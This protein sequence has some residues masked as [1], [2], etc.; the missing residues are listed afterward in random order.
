MKAIETHYK[1]YRFRSRLEA[2][3]AVFFDALQ[4][5]WE[6]E[7]EGFDLD[8]AGWYLP[9][10]WLPELE[11]WVEVK[12]KDPSEA[13]KLK[14]MYLCIYTRQDVFIVGS[15]DLQGSTTLCH[16]VEC[17]NED[18]PPGVY[19]DGI[20]LYRTTEGFAFGSDWTNCDNWR[21]AMSGNDTLCIMP[22]QESLD[23]EYPEV[24][25]FNHPLLLKAFEAA[26]S[27]R[28]EYRTRST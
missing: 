6:Y 25:G 28:F 24:F 13:E 10:F 3:W 21:W 26:R 11:T 5:K 27:A 19:Y 8:E 14:A 18:I 23:K 12:G 22:Y 1:G 15:C 20:E 17:H 2:R 4:V 7:K 16:F 9:D